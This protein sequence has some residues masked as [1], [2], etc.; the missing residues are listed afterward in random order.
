MVGANRSQKASAAILRMAFPH[1]LANAFRNA[2]G[3]I[4]LNGL[5]A[6]AFR[7]M[8]SVVLVPPLENPAPPPALERIV[9]PTAEWRCATNSLVVIRC[10]SSPRFW[11]RAPPGRPPP[12]PPQDRV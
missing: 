3:C 6:V 12:T 10:D 11:P 7:P 8:A 4:T 1:N 5:P 2:L 9:P